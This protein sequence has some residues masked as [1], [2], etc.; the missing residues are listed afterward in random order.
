[1]A[2]FLTALRV[3]L[4]DQRPNV[5]LEQFKLHDIYLAENVLI[6]FTMDSDTL[7]TSQ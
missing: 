1:M 7:I 4:D 6:A 5:F 3:Y 2:D